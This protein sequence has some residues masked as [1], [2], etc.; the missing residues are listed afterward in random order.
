MPTDLNNLAYPFDPTGT[1][2][3]NKIVNEQQVLTAN[4]FRDYHFIVP[5]WAPYFTTSLVAKHRALDNTVRLL[6][7]GQDY[8]CTHEFIS[9]SRA[10]ATPI[11]GSISFTN[12]TLAGVIILEY[13]TLGGIWTQDENKIAEILE[14]RLH[15]PRITAWDEVVDMPVSFPVIDHEW[16]LVDMVG[17]AEVLEALNAIE[18]VLR[19]TGDAGLT[20]HLADFNNPH[21]VNATQ[22]GLGLVQNFP[23][24][25]RAEAVAGTAGNRYMT[26]EMSYAQL[27]DRGL[28]PLQAHISNSANPHGTT[29]LQ[30]GAYSI[31]QTDTLLTGKLDRLGI[32]YDT[33]RFDGR[34]P[35]EYRDWA[36]LGTAANSIRL[37]NMTVGELTAQILTGTSANSSKLEGH[38]YAD[39]VAT[40]SGGVADNTNHFEGLTLTQVTAQILAGKAADSDK[41]DG[42][43]YATAKADILSGKAAD[44]LLFD[45]HTYADTRTD[46]L[47]GKS[48]DSALLDGK[49]FTQVVA[50][51][52]AGVSLVDVYP[53]ITRTDTGTP[54]FRWTRIGTA[55]GVF[56]TGPM[57]QDLTF[58]VAGADS[59]LSDGSALYQ[60]N[61]TYKNP[62]APTAFAPAI[63]ATRLAGTDNRLSFA[64]RYDGTAGTME[65]FVKTDATRSALNVFRLI[66]ATAASVDTT[67]DPEVNEP[68]GVI[69]ATTAITALLSDVAT[70]RA[71]T[72]TALLNITQAFVDLRTAIL[73]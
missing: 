71:D 23:I 22:L 36:L 66:G 61:V 8:Y 51:A 29:A 12:L 35:V 40:L 14:D 3:S 31:A 68:A 25:T 10:C 43:D 57:A 63:S 60:V 24:A 32:A 69:Y 4:N 9:A 39:L 18:D 38:T 65:V 59:P 19:Q 30:V 2:L 16:D 1:L 49:T 27:N 17:Q 7:E 34:T 20:I 26:P 5:R 55:T 54:L 15:N 42:K 72:E 44:S 37:G 41:F 53:A 13:Q 21:R 6:V 33:N 50:L 73:A 48:A 62:I 45:G 58:L 46:I 28:V 56:N 47:S 64:Y 67:A 70:L 11:A 52:S